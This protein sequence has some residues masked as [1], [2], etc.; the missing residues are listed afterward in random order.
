MTPLQ[1]RPRIILPPPGWRPRNPTTTEKLDIVIR[2]EG[3]CAETGKKLGT[4]RETR[5]DHRPPIHER[6]W[7]EAKQDTIPPGAAVVWT[8]PET[9]EEEQLIFAVDRRTHEADLTPRDIK[10]MTK[11]GNLRD[12]ED[13]HH[14]R[15]EMKAAGIKPP[16]RGSIQSPGFD[17]RFKRPM[18]RRP[19]QK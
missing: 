7:D 2:Q 6:E 17:R 5:F 9:G 4:L 15:M 13:E 10:R 12:A 8:D 16:K 18:H 3:K 1:A 14:K 19:E 11:V